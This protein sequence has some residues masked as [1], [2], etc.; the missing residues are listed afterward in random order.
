MDSLISKYA[1]LFTRVDGGYTATIPDIPGVGAVGRTL[2]ETQELIKE[3]LMN[4]A[5]TLQ[6]KDGVEVPPAQSFT[7]YLAI[8]TSQAGWAEKP[9]TWKFIQL[10]TD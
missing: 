10:L 6:D 2:E 7:K 3:A 9:N 4:H 5:I 1:I 8:A